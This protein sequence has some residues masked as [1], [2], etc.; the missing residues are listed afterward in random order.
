MIFRFTAL[1]VLAGMTFMA[2]CASHAGP[3]YTPTALSVATATAWQ[4]PQANALRDAVPHAGSTR[5]LAD[6]WAQFNERR[7]TR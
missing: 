7:W 5:R 4:A 6:W 3:D 1:P 2:G